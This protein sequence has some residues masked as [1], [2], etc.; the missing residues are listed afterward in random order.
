MK[1]FIIQVSNEEMS[2][3]IY[4]LHLSD[5]LLKKKHMIKFLDF[6]KFISWIRFLIKSYFKMILEMNF[7]GKRKLKRFELLIQC[8]LFCSQKAFSNNR[9]DETY[10]DEFFKFWKN[11]SFCFMMT[12]KARKI[13]VLISNLASCN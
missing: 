8:A 13:Q 4:F 5:I 1:I 10:F 7:Y 12:Y 6:A 11:C 3:F 2:C 9:R